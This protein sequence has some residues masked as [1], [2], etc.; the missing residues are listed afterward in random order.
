MGRPLVS[1]SFFGYSRSML[2]F[3]YSYLVELRIFFATFR[4]KKWLDKEKYIYHLFWWPHRCAR[5][6]II[7]QIRHEFKKYEP[8]LQEAG[9]VNVYLTHCGTYG[10]YDKPNI[11]YVYCHRQPYK[12]V[13]TI[14]H[15][16]VHLRTESEVLEHGLSHEEKERLVDERV[17][18]VLKHRK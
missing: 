11:I 9:T 2:T 7:E 18:A 13:E 14:V 10:S 15:E 3:K 12:I 16:I 5:K 17:Q 4:N 8:N 1:P 6:K